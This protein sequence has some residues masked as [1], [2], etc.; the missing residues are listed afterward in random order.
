MVDMK[1]KLPNFLVVGTAKV[2]TT[3]LASYINA[4]PQIEIPRKE[5][6][7]FNRSEFSDICLPYPLQRPM[8]SVVQT[9]GE[10][11]AVFSSCTAPILGEVGTGYLYHYEHSIPSIKKTLGADVKIIIILRNPIE[12]A[13]SAY[14]HFRKDV[15][16]DK[17][18]EESLEMEY[19]RIRQKWD[20][21][22]HY[23]AVG[24]YYQQVQAYKQSFPEVYVLFYEDLKANPQKFISNI[25]SILGADDFVPDTSKVKNISGEPKFPWMQKLITHEN[26]L[27]SLVRP[28][29]RQVMSDENRSLLRKYLKSKNIKSAESISPEA[30]NKL[31][32]YYKNDIKLL[33]SL[34]Q[35]NLDHWLDDKQ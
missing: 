30:H 14:Q 35:K 19:Y 25:Y 32:V 4:H 33:S 22:W 20:F 13:Y 2:G 23:K 29:A 9:I 5:T 15:F 26:A 17:S 28:L 1:N 21:M 12:R 3:S 7:Y 11:Q 18:F 6:F 24:L 10:Y 31:K 16:E 8:S 27:K 34:L